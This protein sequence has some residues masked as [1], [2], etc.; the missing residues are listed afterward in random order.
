M[1]MLARPVLRQGLA[2]GRIVARRNVHIENTVGNNMP[3]KYQGRPKAFAFKLSAFL[4]SGFAI[5][6]GA[7][8]W[9]LRKSAAAE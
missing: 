4:L 3:F 1:S 8:W 7:A 9:Q 2:Q 5:P 6:F